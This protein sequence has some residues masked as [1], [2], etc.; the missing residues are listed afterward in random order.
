MIFVNFQRNYILY[1][2]LHMR[3]FPINFLLFL[4]HLSNHKT[5]LIF[6]HKKVL[7]LQGKWHIKYEAHEGSS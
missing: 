1:P 7:K 2:N 6:S 4:N 5:K 3:A